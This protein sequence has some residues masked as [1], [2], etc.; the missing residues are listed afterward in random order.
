VSAR[1]FHSGSRGSSPWGNGDFRL[2][3]ESL[4]GGSANVQILE[5]TAMTQDF[6]SWTQVVMESRTPN[7]NSTVCWE[8]SGEGR[9]QFVLQF[10]D[11]TLAV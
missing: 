8:G 1:P 3:D 7:P 4:S 6:Q 2:K 10:P 5:A 11:N 9:S